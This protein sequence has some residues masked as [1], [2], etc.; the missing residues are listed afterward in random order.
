MSPT[1]PPTRPAAAF[2]FFYIEPSKREFLPI[3]QKFVGPI[4]LQESEEIAPIG[5]PPARNTLN[6]NLWWWPP[7]CAFG[8]CTA[9]NLPALLAACVAD[10]PPPHAA[11]PPA[12]ASW[13]ATRQ[14]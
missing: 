1:H 5:A 10:M 11:A 2:P 6:R 13:Q 9:R 12:P 4:T 14:R 3:V 8:S 7:A